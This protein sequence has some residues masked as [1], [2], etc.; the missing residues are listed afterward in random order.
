MKASNHNSTWY[1]CYVDGVC[2]LVN[3]TMW[4]A[5]SWLNNFIYYLKTMVQQRLIILQDDYGP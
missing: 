4:L 1:V 2:R 5:S 3:C